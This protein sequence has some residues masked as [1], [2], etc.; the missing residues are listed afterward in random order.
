MDRWA[1]C[2]WQNVCV[3]DLSIPALSVGLPVFLCPTP[4]S[5]VFTSEVVVNSWATCSKSPSSSDDHPP[6]PPHSFDIGDT[7]AFAGLFLDIAK[8]A[9]SKI[10][11]ALLSYLKPD[12]LEGSVKFFG[13][14]QLTCDSIKI[15]RGVRSKEAGDDDASNAPQP[16]HHHPCLP[17]PFQTRD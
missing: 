12:H 17:G 13:V 16:N 1:G 6:T 15:T 10:S 3:C 2:G 8:P 7:E 5:Q 14:L 4:G 9:E 11:N